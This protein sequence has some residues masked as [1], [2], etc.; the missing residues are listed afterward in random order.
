MV[1]GFSQ[2]C[3][4]KL[5]LPSKL[6]GLVKLERGQL[7]FSGSR[8]MLQFRVEDWQMARTSEGLEVID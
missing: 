4:I 1:N 8:D 6:E 5:E 2:V 3:K 7:T